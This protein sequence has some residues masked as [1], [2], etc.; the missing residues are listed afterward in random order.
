M[1]FCRT[2]DVTISVN[3]PDIR[4]DQVEVIYEAKDTVVAHHKDDVTI[5]VHSLDPIDCVEMLDLLEREFRSHRHA[6][7]HGIVQVA[8]LAIDS[9]GHAEWDRKHIPAAPEAP[10]FLL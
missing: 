8:F 5:V 6:G 2:V 4:Q 1:W 10:H 3:Y 7:A 9:D